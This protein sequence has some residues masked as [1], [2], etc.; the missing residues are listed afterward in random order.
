MSATGG[1][2]GD[3]TIFQIGTGGSGFVVTHS[4]TDGAN[5]GRNLGGSM[6]QFGSTLA[7][8]SE[9]GGTAGAG[10]MFRIGTDNTGF[11]VTARLPEER[12]TAPSRSAR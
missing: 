4:F 11:A 1:T 9:F 6:V 8:M 2:T 5:D 12:P 7:G 3:G 10:V